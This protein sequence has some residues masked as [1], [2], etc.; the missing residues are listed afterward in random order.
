M[1]ITITRQNDP[2]GGHERVVAFI[3]DQ[4]LSGRIKVGDRLLPE[5]DLAVALGVSRPVVREAL[6]SL[7]AIGAVE[8]RPGHGTVVKQPSLSALADF[9]SFV[10]AQQSGALDDVM[11]ARIAI[12]LHAIRLACERA[13]PSDIDRISDAFQQIVR[14]MKDPAAGGAADFHFH[15]MIVEAA[16]SATLSN[17]YAAISNLLRRSHAERRSEI[18][19][20]KGI[21]KYLID[22]HEEI[23]KAIVARDVARAEKLLLAHFEIGADL[24]RDQATYAYARKFAKNTQKSS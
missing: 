12:E 5:R 20:V 16:R 15:T 2:S 23:L 10:L 9:F 4:L 21:D 17:I 7:A 6:R 3:R 22:H 14:T 19:H 13:L 18:T 8:I 11:E 1:T 24:R